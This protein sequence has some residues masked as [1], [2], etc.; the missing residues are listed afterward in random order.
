M[1][2]STKLLISLC[3]DQA[4][5]ASTILS[6]AVDS[7]SQESKRRWL[8][9]LSGIQLEGELFIL[10]G[11][12][13]NPVSLYLAKNKKEC[14]MSL[15]EGEPLGSRG[16]LAE[17][18]RESVHFRVIS[19]VHACEVDRPP[20]LGKGGPGSTLPGVPQIGGPGNTSSGVPR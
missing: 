8:I 20:A 14:Q 3:K 5:Q 11:R 4:H 19:T 18:R 7:R 1:A 9:S 15:D 2:V 10:R 6:E 13:G 16:P 17:G 12:A